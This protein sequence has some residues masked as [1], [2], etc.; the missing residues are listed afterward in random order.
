MKA[1][2]IGAWV[3]LV[4]FGHVSFSMANSDFM[5]MCIPVGGCLSFAKTHLMFLS[6]P[7][8]HERVPRR[9]GCH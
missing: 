4:L 7:A 9:V 3:G 8:T 6:D 5:A 1:I 2:I